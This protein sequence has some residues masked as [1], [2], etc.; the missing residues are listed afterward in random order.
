MKGGLTLTLDPLEGHMNCVPGNGGETTGGCVLGICQHDTDSGD[1][2]EISGELRSEVGLRCGW[3][4]VFALA[5]TLPE[6]VKSSLLRK[7]MASAP[8]FPPRRQ[9]HP[10]HGARVERA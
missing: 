1:L 5:Q 4:V 9:S 7:L 3:N 2:V 10:P 6:A 8:V